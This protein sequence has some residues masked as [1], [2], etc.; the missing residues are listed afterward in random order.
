MPDFKGEG[1]IKFH[2]HY[3]PNKNFEKFFNKNFI[4]LYF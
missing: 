2:S 3:T 1:N 4:L